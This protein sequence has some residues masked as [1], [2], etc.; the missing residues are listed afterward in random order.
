MIRLSIADMEKM[1]SFQL[2]FTW[3]D[4][5]IVSIVIGVIGSIAIPQYFKARATSQQ[6]AC[7][8]NL[9]FIDHGK[10]QTSMAFHLTD[11]DTV[12]TISVNQYLKGSTTPICPSGGTYTYNLIGE[13]PHCTISTPTSHVFF[14]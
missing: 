6:N 11:G 8:V 2:A 1:K 4:F 5:I 10:L 13:G 3:R 9:L 7:I 12:S 14:G